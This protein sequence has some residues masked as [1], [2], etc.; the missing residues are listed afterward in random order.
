MSGTPYNGDPSRQPDRIAI[1]VGPRAF[2]PR[3][4]ARPR[5]RA[6]RVSAG[7]ALVNRRHLLAGMAA[8]G[9]AAVTPSAFAQES[10]LLR[11]VSTSGV[12]HG[13]VADYTKSPAWREGMPRGANRAW[14]TYMR[15]VV[16]QITSG[17]PDLVL[18]TGDMV[19]GRW[20]RYLPGDPQVYGPRRTWSEKT[21]MIHRAADTIYPWMR[22]W[23]ADWT[24]WWAMGDHEIG[25]IGGSGVIPP[26]T[27]RYKAHWHWKEAWRRHFGPTRY[28]RRRGPVGVITLDPFVKSNRG[29][30]VR[31]PAA[32]FD[33]IVDTV[34]RWRADGVR[35][36]FLQ[37]EIPAVGPNRANGTS[38]LLLENGQNL[39]DV[40]AD[41]GA[42]LLLAAE[43]HADTTHTNGGSTPMQVVHGGRHTRASWLTIDVF[44]DRLELTLR[45]SVGS[46]EGSGLIW[47]P[48]SHRLNNQP[49]AG[50]PQVTGRAV[51][52]AGGRVSDRTGYLQE[53][54]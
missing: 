1:D 9:L 27:F 23:W 2:V 25:D 53:G 43:F 16:G 26:D 30:L 5:G 37:C 28:A 6:R 52:H 42:D 20:Y 12:P 48:T 31:I 24:V 18:H 29:V 54:I 38:A 14:R 3:G 10:R 49:V 21:R 11:V 19:E 39:L 35:W 51:V 8:M 41:V 22:Q 36:V 13:D 46:A 40:L 15:T 7:G 34:A 32:H 47:A 44:T 33:W 4:H 17:S 50:V 45:E